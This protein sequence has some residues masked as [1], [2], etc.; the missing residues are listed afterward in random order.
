[1]SVCL[2]VCFFHEEQLHLESL[3]LCLQLQLSDTDVIS[4]LS[5][6]TDITLHRLAHGQLPLTL[7][8]EVISSKMGIVNLQN[9]VGMVHRT[10]KDLSPQVLDRLEI[11]S[12]VSH[13]GSLL[14]QVFLDFS[15]QSPISSLQ[16]PHPQGRRLGSHSGIT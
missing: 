13:L 7:D 15:L 9:D 3:D 14:L 6:P 12:P 4:D 1:M 11:M 8:S 2:F 16:A 5:E 10:C